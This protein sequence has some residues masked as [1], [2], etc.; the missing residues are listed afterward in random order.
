MA[1]PATKKTGAK[2][3][4]APK[5]QTTMKVMKAKARQ[6]KIAKGRYAKVMVFKGKKEKTVGGLKQES[7]IKNKRGKVV[8][9]KASALGKRRFK[10]I[11]GWVEAVMAAREAMH[12]TGFVAING[13]SL[14]GQALY[15]KA[16]QLRAGSSGSIPSPAAAAPGGA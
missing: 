2:A 15:V 16:K 8:S 6:T 13:K 14:Q 11:E 1:L 9:K 10:N 3:M 7:L 4:K 5:A 12:T